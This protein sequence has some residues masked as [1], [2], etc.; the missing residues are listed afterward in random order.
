MTEHIAEHD[1]AT[2]DEA[3]LAAAE[4]IAGLLRAELG[5]HEATSLIVTGG[6]SPAQC[7]AALA[8]TAI[9]WS[10]VS[11]VLSDERWVS[12]TH[13]DS[14]EKLVRG[15]LLQ[16]RA[17][18]ANLLSI[19]TSSATPADRCK[20]LD[21]IL[22]TLPMPFACALLGM[23]D[24]GHFASLFP[25]AENLAA[26]LAADNPA[27]CL[28]VTTAASEHLRISLTLAA[29]LRSAQIVLL[30]FG[31]IKRDVYEHAKAEAPVYPVTRLLSQE[32]VPVHV[33]WAP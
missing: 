16:G 12:P 7:Y 9:D 18:A 33:F 32:R 20:T 19:Y 26:G 2:R 22:P 27:W 8:T 25:D 23:G 14:N 11:I 28:P 10:Q 21:D 24:D 3:S 6:S 29:L 13:K 1:F 30:F 4:H 31:T 17:A 15:S 5:E